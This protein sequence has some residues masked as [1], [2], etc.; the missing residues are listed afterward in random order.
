M[1]IFDPIINVGKTLVNKIV[2]AGEQ[3]WDGVQIG[4]NATWGE[5]RKVDDLAKGLG[6]GFVSAATTVGD[7]FVSFGNDVKSFTLSATGDVVKFSQTSFSEVAEWTRSAAGTV[8]SFS[9]QA[10]N[11]AMDGLITGFVKG[12]EFLSGL[13]TEDLP[14]L[15]SQS[16]AAAQVAQILFLDC[17]QGLE[18][19]ADSGTLTIAIDIKLKAGLV[20]AATARAGIYVGPKVAGQSSQWGF[21]TGFSLTPV[22]LMG[23]FSGASLTIEPELTLLHGRPAEVSGIKVFKLGIKA[24]LGVI[25]VDAEALFRPGFPPDPVGGRLGV[26]FSVQ[27][28]KSGKSD[29]KPPKPPEWSYRP[30]IATGGV[31]TALTSGGQQVVSDLKANLSGVRMASITAM[32]PGRRDRALATGQIAALSQK[33]FLPMA[34]GE[35]LSGD[36]TADTAT[37]MRLA[38]SGGSGGLA[39]RMQRGTVATRSIF[40]IVPGLGDPG[41]YSIETPGD[42]PDAPALYL[43]LGADGNLGFL[44]YSAIADGMRAT[45][46][47]ARYEKTSG[48]S[49]TIATPQSSKQYLQGSDMALSPD[50]IF[51][52][53]SAALPAMRIG[54]LSPQAVNFGWAYTLAAR[55]VPAMQQA[56]LLPLQVLKV[57]EFRRSGDGRYLLTLRADGTLAVLVGSSPKDVRGQVWASPTKASGAVFAQLGLDGRLRVYSGS[58]PDDAGAVVWQS[59]A[60]GQPGACFAAVTNTGGLAIFQGA[61]DNLGEL[62]WS[63]ASGARAY[64]VG[65]RRVAMLGSNGLYLGTSG[66]PSLYS[67]QD[68]PGPG[69]VNSCVGEHETIELLT[70]VNGKVA[71]RSLSRG[72]LGLLK[73]GDGTTD[74]AILDRELREE[75]MFQQ[76]QNG[77]G[78][79]SFQ[80]KNQK[81]LCVKANKAIDLSATSLTAETRFRVVPLLNDPIA[82]SDQVFTITAAHSGKR[83]EGEGG[84]FTRTLRIV[85]NSGT[86]ADTQ[87]WRISH[88]GGGY[89]YIHN[90]ATGLSLDISGAAITDGASVIQFPPNQGANQTFALLPQDDG[91]YIIK[92]KHSGKVLDVQGAATADGAAVIQYPQHSGANQRFWLQLAS[93]SG[94]DVVALSVLAHLETA[95]DMVVANRQWVGGTIKELVIPTGLRERGLR[96]EALMVSFVNKPEWMKDLQL[97]YMGHLEGIG[98]TIT[99]TGEGNLLG[100]RGQSR[101]LEGF[102]IKL[103]IAPSASQTAR[104]LLKGLSV[105]YQAKVQDLGFTDICRDGE[106]CGTRGQGKRIEGLRVYIVRTS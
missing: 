83:L 1:S 31:T 25:S 23:A 35:I 70:L 63:S 43:C 72:Y 92:A 76:I 8:A 33:V 37:A 54:G 6:N 67:V 12:W 73:I 42:T 106:F 90:L 30:N 84:R 51:V 61:P 14:K 82:N 22:D 99:W 55:P 102:A 16:S 85:T 38:V 19:L 41:R 96:V 56:T 21:F 103:T 57:G 64:V 69:A 44:P 81:Y 24:Q 3:G 94:Q 45:W 11:T 47:L 60:L 104:D 2:H 52:G 46:D 80:G 10:F 27:V 95:G 50:E 9:T 5:L 59:D 7:S 100:T 28:F 88:L 78:T 98:D 77:D 32:N 75:Q 34:Y 93:T 105:R 18:S 71:L 26:G 13:L 36:G 89:C 66:G 4:V 39:V 40:R 58:G 53:L 15:D 65:S 20:G 48:A 29:G 17:Q 101:R 68:L 86:A 79:L 97:S 49:L 62:V 87:R 91:T 74:E